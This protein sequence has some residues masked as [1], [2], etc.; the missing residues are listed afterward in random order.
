MDGEMIAAILVAAVLAALAFRKLL[1]RG[2]KL[3]ARSALWGVLL[4]A[5]APVSAQA[6]IALGVNAVNALTLGLLGLPGL[7]AL[8]LL[9]WFTG[10]T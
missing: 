8:L 5:L 4:A 6:G 3:L 1:W 7:G 2:V 10:L 9:Q